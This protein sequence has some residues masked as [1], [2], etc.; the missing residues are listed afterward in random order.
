ME[1][2]SEGTATE[3]STAGE[4]T[5]S[6]GQAQPQPGTGQENDGSAST[7]P[8]DFTIPE[9]YDLDANGREGLGTFFKS[10]DGMSPEERNQAFIDEHFRIRGEMTSNSESAWEDTVKGWAAEVSADPE[11]GGADMGEKLAGA[12]RAM[13]S[14]SQPAVDKDG[15]AVLHEG[16]GSKGQQ[17]TEMEV[18]MNQSGW[19]NHPSVIRWMHRVNEA[20]SQDKFVKGDM[21]PFVKEKSA[22]ETMYPNM[23]K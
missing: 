3:E 16:G 6:E 9:G 5:V 2:T 4:D 21:K 12:R 23:T 20:M 10:L 15:K 19:G 18:V 11:I 8:A 17:M 1:D 22:A 14:F 7:Q 13:N